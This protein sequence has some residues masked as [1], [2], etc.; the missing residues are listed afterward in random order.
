MEEFLLL[1]IGIYAVFFIISLAVQSPFWLLSWISQRK[2]H[3]PNHFIHTLTGAFF[4]V[5]PYLFYAENIYMPLDE[6]SFFSGCTIF[7]FSLISP[8]INYSKVKEWYFG[9]SLIP[10][11]N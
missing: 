2:I 8:Y 11:N 5:L 9:D 4:I 10:K 1:A 3:N 7:V 6:L